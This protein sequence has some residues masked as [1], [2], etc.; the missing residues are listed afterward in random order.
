MQLEWHN[1][2]QCTQD[3]KYTFMFGNYSHLKLLIKLPCPEQK[4]GQ[5]PEQSES[6]NPSLQVHF[7]ESKSHNLFN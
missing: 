7:R 4:S 1:Y 6:P 5:V 2:H 3:H